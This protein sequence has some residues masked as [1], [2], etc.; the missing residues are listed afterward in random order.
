MMKWP[1]KLKILKILIGLG[2]AAIAMLVMSSCGSDLPD[3]VQAAYDDLPEQIDFN[4]HVK[5]ILSDKCYHCHGPDKNSRKAEFRLDT[6][7]GAFSK[8]RAGQYAFV[9]GDASGSHAIER[10]LSSD[11]LFR[12]PPPESNLRLSPREIATL[13]KWV[14]QG[15]DWKPHWAFIPP[16]KPDVPDGIPKEW[17][18]SNEID[19]FIFKQIQ[20]NGLE[21]AP[22]AD[23][24]RLLRRVTMDLTGLPPT[25][26]EMDAFLNDTSP[27]AYEKVVER[28]LR[29]NAHAERLTVDWLDVSRYADSHGMHADGY[30]LMWPWRDWVIKAFNE[31]MPFDRFVTWQLAGDLLPNAT[32]EQRLATAFN[33]NHPMTDEGGVIDEE[34]RLKYV[35]DRTSTVGTALLGLTMECASCHDHKFDPLSQKE[36]YQMSAFFNNIKELGMTGADGN[37]GPSLLLTDSITDH[38]IA[39][40]KAMIR[41]KEQ[42]IDQR[43]SQVTLPEK[44]LASIPSANAIEGLQGRYP[45]ESFKVGAAG[46]FFVDGNSKSVTKASPVFTAGKKG[47]AMRFTGEYD[48]LYLHGAGLFESFDPFSCGAWINTIKRQPTKTQTIL[49]NSGQKN[50]FWRGWD[51]FLDDQ[52]RLNVR[53]I[54]SLPHNYFQ[55]TTTDSVKRNEWT[56]AFFTY[57][58]SGEAKGVSIFINGRKVEVTVPYDRLYKS[59][60]PVRLGTHVPENRPLAVGKS[61]RLHTGEFGIFKGLMDDIRIFDRELSSL[62]I[63]VLYNDAAGADVLPTQ[64]ENDLQQYRAQLDPRIRKEKAEIQDLRKQL[65][66]VVNPIDEVMVMEEMETPRETFLL[67]RGLYDNPAER[68]EPGTPEAVMPFPKDLPLNRLG[69]AKWIFHEKN[70]LAARVAVNRYWQLIFGRGL[71]KTAYDFG[72]Q[73][74]LPSHPELLDWLAVDFM[75]SGW[76]VRRLLRQMVLST[77]YR[78]SS[79]ATPDV[80]EKDPENI[81]L[82]RS[83]SYRIQAEFIRDNALAASGLLVRDVGGP[84]VKPYQPAGLW[85]ELSNYSRKLLYY[86]QD[87]GKALYRRSMYTFIRRTS[88]PPFMTI[89][90]APNR[91]VC[92]V[93]RERTNTPLQ[94]LALLNDPQFVE[95]S[96]VLAERVMHMNPDPSEQVK[97]AFRLAISRRPN[98]REVEVLMNLLVK[99]K[100][101]YTSHPKE[102]GKLLDVGD[103][104]IQDIG[105]S[106]QLAAMTIVAN[107]IL[108]HDEA[109]MKR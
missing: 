84:S 5:P 82:A 11:S 87:S 109:Y 79:T 58:G 105:N 12:M 36:F 81:L 3:E 60:I 28:L 62:E 59:I 19:R 43:N 31:N 20:A 10:I 21:P 37:Y 64:D 32:Q 93:G 46:Q 55:V 33:R 39:N 7:E 92:T 14:E 99:E 29:S 67:S 15:A 22:P 75:K 41:Q 16:S 71:V 25:L 23:K 103:Y 78:Q 72:S 34:F 9:R 56:H 98:D 40:I 17:N 73:G 107:T 106:A 76:D 48:E 45:L 97:Y 88:P 49:G 104:K 69:L 80:V 27:D 90:D 63:K 61:Y 96:K 85:R 6:E 74:S 4:Y 65:L 18:A 89:F 52:N 86:K 2:I 102:A 1:K 51:F 108:N 24:E 50:N 101:F 53:L 47:K 54:N 83:P 100:A 30:R 91:D 13:V 35:A 66:E 42:S 8:L 38:K 57:D 70:P 44:Q 68:V 94:A 95:A 77:T 26:E